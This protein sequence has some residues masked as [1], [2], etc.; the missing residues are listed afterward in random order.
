LLNPAGV[1]YRRADFQLQAGSPAMG[2][3]PTGVDIGAAVAGGVSLSGEPAAFTN[4]KG[5]TLTVGFS[6][7]TG[8]N[9]AGYLAYKYRVNGG[10]YSVEVPAGTPITLANLPDG[11]YT[12]YVVGKNDAGVY[13]ADARATAS[14]TW[15][16]DTKGPKVLASAFRY[17]LPAHAVTVQFDEDLGA[18]PAEAMFALTNLTTGQAIGSDL[19]D[20]TYDAGTRTATITFPFLPP[21]GRLADGNYRLVVHAAGVADRATNLLDGNGDGTAGD[22]YT[23]DFFQ[24]SGDANRDRVVDFNDLVALAQHYNAPSGESWATGDFNADGAVDFNDLVSLAQ[25]YN[26]TLPAAAPP[27]VAVIA[28]GVAPATVTS[29]SRPATKPLSSK[30]PAFGNRRI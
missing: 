26:V 1:V 24:L 29:A 19:F 13:Q 15:T 2:A 4:S 6:A 28:D 30:R 25:N 23:F 12:V 16:V 21:A 17:D 20:A 10:A 14:R 18:P 3:G 22:D 8:T 11:T 27:A 7:G 9:A 5:A